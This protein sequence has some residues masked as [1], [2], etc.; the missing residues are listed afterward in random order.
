MCEEQSE[1]CNVINLIIQNTQNPEE[2]TNDTEEIS[3][4]EINCLKYV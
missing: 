4:L 1:Y 2:T 3:V